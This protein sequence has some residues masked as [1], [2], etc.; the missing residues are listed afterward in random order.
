MN[1]QTKK[2]S[3]SLLIMDY[4]IYPRHKISSYHV[5]ELSQSIQGGAKFPPIAWDKNSKKILDGFH[6]VSAYKRIYGLEYEVEGFEID[7]KD[8]SEMIIRG[9][10]YND[11]HGLRLSAWDKARFI[12]IARANSISEE[13]IIK[14][15][16]TPVKRIDVLKRRIVPIRN[17]QGQFVGEA[18]LKHGQEK[19]SKK[20]DG[21]YITQEEAK[22]NESGSSTGLNPLIRITTLIKDL[23]FKSFEVTSNNIEI[24]KELYHCLGE[25]IEEY[26][27][28]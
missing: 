27:N 9:F 24:V 1:D 19:M 2:I 10:E 3:L 18:Q 17:E 20:P 6:R 28:E 8:K 22:Q 7:C 11:K 26:E 25:A 15:M 5:N 14:T 23:D 16:N 13:L 21:I 4:D 12:S